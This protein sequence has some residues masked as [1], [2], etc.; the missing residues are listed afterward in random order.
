MKSQKYA[1]GNAKTYPLESTGRHR[2]VTS[3]KD[4]KL[5]YAYVPGAITITNIT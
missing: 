4:S 3:R 1:H 5:I 2:A